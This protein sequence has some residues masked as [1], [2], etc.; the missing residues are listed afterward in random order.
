MHLQGKRGRHAPC[1]IPRDCR[2]AMSILNEKREEVGVSSGNPYIFALPGKEQSYQN[3][4]Q[5][6]NRFAKGAELE[7]PE[8]VT[9]TKLRKYLATSSQILAMDK[10]V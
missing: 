1:L 3:A 10:Y 7:F 2:R 9:S 4:W 5:A 8:F 6:L